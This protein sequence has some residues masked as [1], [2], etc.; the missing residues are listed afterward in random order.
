MEQTIKFKNDKTNGS[1]E[2]RG[3]NGRLNVYS[4]IVNQPLTAFGDLRVAELSPQIQG[5]FEYTVDNTFLVNKTLVNGGTVTQADGMGI[6]TTT[7]TTGSMAMLSSVAKAKYRPGLGGVLRFTAL[8]TEGVAATEQY[9]G[10]QDEMGSSAA[11]KNGYSIGFDGATFGYHRFQDDVKFSTDLADWDDPLDGE[12]DSG[13]ILD[14]TKL[15]IFFI[16][17][18][19]LGA[20]AVKIWAET[21]DG[22]MHLVHTDRYAGSNIV[23]SVF[24]PNFHFHI[25]VDNMATTSN[26]VVKSSSYAYFIEGKTSQMELHQPIL[27]SGEKSQATV[28]TQ[29]ALFTIRNKTTYASKANFVDILFTAFAVSI[30]ASSA[31]NLASVSFILDATLGGTPSYADIDTN[32]SVM[33]ID[34]AGTTVT[35]GTQVLTIPLAGKNDKEILELIAD[36]T[37]LQP[38]KS[39]TIAVSSVNSATMK[40]SC[41]WKELF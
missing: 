27:G 18:Q 39:L 5:S 31:N 11:F 15:N 24:N 37:V 33:E 12:G 35:N 4:H 7:T 25:H 34:V 17:F 20:G 16:Q 19:Y 30:E 13:M 26:L 23:P 28:T 9:V 3:S 6:A 29:V 2:M 8:F 40:G 22:D 38:G 10:L 36:A 32:N 1:E 14:P 41:S 21:P